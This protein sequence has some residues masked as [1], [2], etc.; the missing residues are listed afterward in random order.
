MRTQRGGGIHKKLVFSL[1]DD[2]P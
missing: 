2:T 1:I